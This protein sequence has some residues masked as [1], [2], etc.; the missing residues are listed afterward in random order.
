MT[1]ADDI[2][3]KRARLAALE[4]ELAWLKD[5]YDLAMSAF[6]FDEAR[7]F[8]P[9]IEAAERERLALAEGL[10]PLP[11]SQAKPAPRRRPLPLRRRRRR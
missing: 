4:S 6:K 11:A 10:P 7:E 1:D 2:A 8:H 3:A 5:Q 9:R